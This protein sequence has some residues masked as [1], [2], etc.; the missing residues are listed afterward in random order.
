MKASLRSPILS[1]ALISLFVASVVNCHYGSGSGLFVSGGN[2]PAFEIRRS[3]SAHVRIFPLFIVTELHP[4]N[5]HMPPLQDDPAKNRVVWKITSNSA[6]LSE[7]IEKIEYGKVPAGFTQETP[8]DG[9][10]EQLQENRLY[11]A[12]GPLS[13]MGD[14]VVRFKIVGGRVITQPLPISRER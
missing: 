4:D 3:R 7:K 12:R 5:E 2:P 1:L 6:D 11:E 13:L 10:A 14:A 8:K 9:S